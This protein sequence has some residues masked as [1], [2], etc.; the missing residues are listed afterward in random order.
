MTPLT[1]TDDMYTGT[2]VVSSVGDPVTRK[3]DYIMT[4]T[5]IPLY[6]ESLDG[7]QFTR[8]DDMYTCIPL[9]SLDDDSFTLKDHW[10]TYIYIHTCITYTSLDGDPFTR[11]DDIQHELLRG[12][13]SMNSSK[14]NTV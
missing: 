5:C 3:D 12:Q 1:T 7:D 2:P 11:T 8:K 10:Y 14:V 13:C 9:E 4:Y 6:L